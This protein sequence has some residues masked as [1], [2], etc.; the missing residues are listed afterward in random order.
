[1]S[2]SLRNDGRIWVP[3]TEGRQAPARPDPGGRA[4]LL[5]G[6]QV[7]RASATWPRATS[8]R[9]PPR[10]SATRAA[11]SG[12]RGLGVYLDFADAIK[13]LGDDRDRARRY[14]N[15]FDMYERI[16]GENA[17]EVPMR[18]YPA[19]HY[20]MGGLWVDYNLM[21]NDPRPVR[22]RRGELLR[23]RREPPRRQRAHAGPGRRLLRPARTPSATTSR[24]EARSRRS[25]RDM[26]QFTEAE[27]D[28]RRAHEAAARRSRA[29][30]RSTSFHRE[31]GQDHVG[32][33]R[34]GAQRSRACKKAL[35]QIPALREEFW[36]N[37]Q[38]PRQRARAEPVARKGRPR[39]R[40]PR[41]R[42]ADVP[43]TRWSA[44]NPAAA[45]SARSTRRPTARPSATTR[46]SAT[47]PPGNT[48]ATASRR[49][50]QGAAGLRERAA[51]A[52]EL[53]VAKRQ[54]R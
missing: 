52:A 17:Y 34:H 54:S 8:P 24:A 51:G 12:P 15:L 47:S 25:P 13:R 48:R 42:R 7:S 39:G 31:A 26:P 43:A 38:R 20:T 33:L 50:A 9:A 11:A 37:V 32:P 23:P 35:Q 5:P 29:S 27:D 10:R 40:L 2:E 22:A 30:A 53:Q 18:I 14:G 46:T 45:T 36:K 3:K 44:T 19:V 6:A 16:T 1:M 28:V 21:S 4:R 41:V 49:S